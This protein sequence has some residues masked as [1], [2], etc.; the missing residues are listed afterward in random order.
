LST[1]T[2]RKRVA[3]RVENLRDLAVAFCRSLT[4]EQLAQALVL[5][6]QLLRAQQVSAPCFELGASGAFSSC[7]AACPRK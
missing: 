2:A 7:R 1:I 6:F 3:R 4:V 5:G